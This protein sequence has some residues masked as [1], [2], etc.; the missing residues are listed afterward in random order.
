MSF[1]LQ[2]RGGTGQSCRSNKSRNS[3]SKWGFCQSITLIMLI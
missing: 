2:L 1:K 3:Y